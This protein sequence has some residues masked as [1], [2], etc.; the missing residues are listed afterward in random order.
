MSYTVSTV[1]LPSLLC[2][3]SSISA[4]QAVAAL[5]ASLAAPFHTLTALSAAPLLLSFALSPRSSRHPYLLYTSLLAVLSSAVPRLLPAPAA[6]G[7]RRQ[8]AGARK[9]QR[10]ARMDA[11]YEVLGDVASEAASEE[12]VDEVNGEEVRVEVEALSRGY[13]IRT[14]I[15]SLGFAMA[16]V[17]LWGDG[18]PQAVVYLS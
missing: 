16:I 17:G 5:S 1:S 8:Q 14:G 7:P 13:V 11:S 6:P 2:L 12:D 9:Q 10:A 4:S 18:A 15:A 3:S